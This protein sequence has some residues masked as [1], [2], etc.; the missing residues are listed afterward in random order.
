[1]MNKLLLNLHLDRIMNYKQLFPMGV[2]ASVVA[3]SAPAA[4]SNS[5]IMP[6]ISLQAHM[7]LRWNTTWV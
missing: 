3:L 1:M 5:A 7:A 4:A 6:L 2:I